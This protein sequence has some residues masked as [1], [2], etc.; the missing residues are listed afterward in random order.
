[1]EK[2]HFDHFALGGV[3]KVWQVDCTLRTW[4]C[5][6]NGGSASRCLYHNPL[7]L[8]DIDQVRKL[9]AASNVE[10]RTQKF[11]FSTTII[12]VSINQAAFKQGERKRNAFQGDP[13][14]RYAG[15]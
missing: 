9:P 8:P 4:L 7:A 6:L 5:G 15:D 14:G 12:A 1:M 10:F 3:L 13:S 11:S 2:L